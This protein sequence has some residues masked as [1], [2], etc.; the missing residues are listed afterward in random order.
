M[1]S[2]WEDVVGKDETYNW[3]HTTNGKT[4]DD[5]VFANKPE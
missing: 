3:E 2:Q 4:A 5:D 1:F